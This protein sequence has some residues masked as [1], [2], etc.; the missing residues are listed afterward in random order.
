MA[1]HDVKYPAS[2]MRDEPRGSL[3]GKRSR[4]IERRTGGR[5]DNT[6]RVN[7]KHRG[8]F[9]NDRR[10]D[11]SDSRSNQAAEISPSVSVYSSAH[12]AVK[13]TLLREAWVVRNI[14]QALKSRKT[15]PF[16]YTLCDCHYQDIR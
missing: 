16:L 2:P 13:L 6:R 15:L 14:S 11:A 9:R 1:H 8:L 5:A 12:L 10:W 4:G 3:G 7:T